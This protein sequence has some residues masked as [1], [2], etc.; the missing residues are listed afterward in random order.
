MPTPAAEKLFMAS[1]NT[2]LDRYRELL[3]AQK[4]DGLMLPNRN[5]DVGENTEAGEYTL[6]DRAYA[7]LL[8]K[9]KGH[10]TEMPEE[11]RLDILAF[12]G[13]L[14]APISTKSDSKGWEQ[15]IKE[16]DELKAVSV[17]TAQ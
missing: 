12:Y 16:L 13:D 2:T 15:V 9:L 5:F 10:Y 6:S 14:S 8:D 7:R 11:L 1:F 4:A 17:A 3:A